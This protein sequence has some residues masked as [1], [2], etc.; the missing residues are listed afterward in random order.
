MNKESI[1]SALSAIIL[2]AIIGLLLAYLSTEFFEVYGSGV[3]LLTPIVC[4]ALSVLIYNRKGQKTLGGSA[5]VAI[6]S[7]WFTLLGFLIVGFEGLICLVMVVPIML[8]LFIVGGMIAYP[9][10]RAIGRKLYGDLSIILLIAFVPM[11][12]GFESRQEY[13][14][15]IREVNTTVIIEGKVGDVWQE[16]IAFSEIPEPTEWLFKVGI[17]YPTDAEIEGEGVGAVRHCNFTT[18]TFVEPITHWEENKRLA[19]DVL[20]QPIPMT[21]LSLHDHIHPPHLDWALRS[22]KGEFRLTDL[23]NGRIELSGTT[24]FHVN[25]QPEPYWG[26]MS[27]YMIHAIHQRVLNHIKL[28]VETAP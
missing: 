22:E 7:G 2:T 6:L 27:D 4:G 13:I 3:F 12:M 24:W 16:V 20:E 23:G 17:A 26:W 28:T 1:I 15:E 25:M 18:R 21:E 19:F 11:F 9:L 10:S 5:G 14:P 8:P